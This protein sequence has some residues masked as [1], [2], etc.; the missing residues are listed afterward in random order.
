MGLTM[1]K[2]RDPFLGFV[3]GDK[4]DFHSIVNGPVTSENHEITALE[5]RGEKKL[6]GEFAAAFISGHRGFVSI[7]SLSRRYSNVTDEIERCLGKGCIAGNEIVIALSD[8]RHHVECPTCGARG[9]AGA[10]KEDAIDNWD[11]LI[12]NASFYYRGCDDC[13]SNRKLKKKPKLIYVVASIRGLSFGGFDEYVYTDKN[14]ANKIAKELGWTAFEFEI[15][16]E[17]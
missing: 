9:S 14:R 13:L 10:D 2:K 6:G 15:S 5:I 17:T 16:E 1:K 7:E 8:G 4:V 3:V 12:I 11:N